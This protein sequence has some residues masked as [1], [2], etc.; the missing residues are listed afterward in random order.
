MRLVGISGSLRKASCNSGLLRYCQGVLKGHGV[1]LDIVPIHELP[2]FN[3]DVEESERPPA[4]IESFR[5]RLDKSRTDGFIF[6][7]CEYN[8]SISAPLKNALDWGSRKGNLFD[9]KPVAIIGAG[10]YA[11]TTRAQ[12]HL[13]DIAFN[14]NMKDL[15]GGF[16][17]GMEIRIQI[18]Q[19]DPP[20]FDGDGNL[21]GEFW[22]KE[23]ATKTLP[24]MIEWAKSL[25]LKQ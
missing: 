15:R 4:S 6:A 1:D 3:E 25:K 7:A 11:G 19:D 12:G 17:S 22:K 8:G 18:F 13:R 5:D 21:V 2:L 14:M 23:I 10:G 9:D 24:G 16:G 20:P